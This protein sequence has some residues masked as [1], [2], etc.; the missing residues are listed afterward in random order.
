[1]KTYLNKEQI[2]ERLGVKPRTALG[3]MMEMNPVAVCGTVR[4]RYVVSEENFERWI[5][6]RTLGKTGTVNAVKGSQ[7]KL[8]RR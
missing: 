5:A 8:A 2:G 3:L 6:R 1:M 4:K 7:K